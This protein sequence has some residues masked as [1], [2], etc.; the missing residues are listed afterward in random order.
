MRVTTTT[1]PENTMTDCLP[2]IRVL[3]LSRVFAGPWATQI[4]ADLGADVVKVE[5]P[6]RGDDNRAMGFPQRDADGVATGQMSSFLAMN[7]GKRSIAIDLATIEG[8]DQLLALVDRADVLV[9]NFKVGS[10]MRWGLGYDVLAARNPRLIQCS[11][12]GF[13]QDGP[14]SQRPSYDAVAQAMSGL[15][16]ITGHAGQG[17]A[18]TGY[19]VADINAGCYAAIAILAALH[20]RD[21]VSSRGQHIDLS[22]LDA[23]FAAQSHIAMNYLLS[24]QTPV[25]A[26]AASQINTP[27]QSFD[28]AQG[29]IMLT[30]G[31]DRQ[32]RTL[33]RLLG[34]DAFAQDP[35]FCDNQS[36]YAHRDALIPAIS[37]V[38]LT[39]TATHW[40]DCL[41]AGGV[42]I[43]PIN[44]FTAA[45]DNPQ[46]RHRGMV[47]AMPDAFGNELPFIANPIRL[48][49][50]PVRY[51]RPPPL[52]D[53]HAAEVL[54]DWIE[55]SKT[56]KPGEKA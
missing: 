42:P 32:F 40:I 18:L 19:S 24:G 3:D 51:D 52:L 4:L 22:L 13:G 33:C 25:Q 12:S 8:R 29:H 37:A 11:I 15:M 28:T 31:N 43:A 27:W 34:L 47:R 5:H 17:P 50:T 23:Q 38:F 48:S 10:M 36:R 26:G 20:H 35:R 2:N 39:Q 21:I 1:F 56:H 6:V 53:A 14:Y 45:L 55:H 9:E 30:I 49:E 46:L 44:D 7:R 54:A 41:G 16:S